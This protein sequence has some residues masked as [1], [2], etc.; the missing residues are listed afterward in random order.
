MAN[1]PPA[2]PAGRS[3]VIL[4]CAAALRADLSHGRAGEALARLQPLRLLAVEG[5]GS[6][7]VI[8]R[9]LRLSAMHAG[10]RMRTHAATRQGVL[11]LLR[12]VQA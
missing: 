2:G 9:H 11:C 4:Q 6:V 7:S 12:P 8:V 5:N 3:S 10:L 1:L